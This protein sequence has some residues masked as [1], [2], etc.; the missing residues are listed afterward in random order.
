VNVIIKS[1]Y[2]I[3]IFNTGNYL[4]RSIIINMMNKRSNDLYNLFNML[5]GRTS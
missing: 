4:T 2:I 5:V 1:K 3:I